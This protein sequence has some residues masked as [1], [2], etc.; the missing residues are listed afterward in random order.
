MV[1]SYK[2]QFME[3]PVIIIYN[4]GQIIL[5]KVLTLSFNKIINKFIHQSPY[6]I[7]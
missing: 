6:K 2:N 5:N 3:K 1:R 4:R 7:G